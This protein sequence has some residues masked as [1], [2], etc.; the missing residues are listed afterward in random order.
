[1]TNKT[2]NVFQNIFRND[3]N[4]SFEI[5]NEKAIQKTAKIFD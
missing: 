2:S 1:M 4:N 3:P 5:K